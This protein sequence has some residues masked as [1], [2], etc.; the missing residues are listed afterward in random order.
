LLCGT[1]ETD[2]GLFRRLNHAQAVVMGSSY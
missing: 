1:K 2:V